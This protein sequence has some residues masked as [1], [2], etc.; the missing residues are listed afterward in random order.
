VRAIASPSQSKRV[1]G[2]PGEQPVAAERVLVLRLAEDGH[3]AGDEPRARLVEMVL[4]QVRDD[5]GVQSADDLLGG[6][7]QRHERVRNL[8]RRVFDRRPGAGVVEHR[9]DEES[10]GRRA[11][12]AGWRGGRG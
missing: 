8:F 2:R 1:L 9:L 11:R 4:V 12:A 3:V 7:R 10:G 6:H 5:H